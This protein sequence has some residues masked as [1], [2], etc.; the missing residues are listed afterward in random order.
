LNGP[1][2]N[3]AAHSHGSGYRIDDGATEVHVLCALAP[4]CTAAFRGALRRARFAR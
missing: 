3:F 1:G 2:R 4:L